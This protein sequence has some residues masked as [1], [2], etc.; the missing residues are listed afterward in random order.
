[1]ES[2]ALSGEASGSFG[3]GQ[4]QQVMGGCDIVLEM[5]LRSLVIDDWCRPKRDLIIKSML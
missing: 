3:H 4:W 5:V 1:M 2:P